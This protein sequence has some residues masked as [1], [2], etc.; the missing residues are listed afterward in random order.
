[1]NF[2]KTMIP[3]GKEAGFGSRLCGRKV[4]N[5]LSQMHHSYMFQHFKADYF[6]SPFTI[7]GTAFVSRAVLKKDAVNSF[8][9]QPESRT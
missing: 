5:G 9:T 8:F 7:P 1:M 2:L 6:E 4:R 3:R